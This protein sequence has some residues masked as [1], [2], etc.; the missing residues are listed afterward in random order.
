MA[1][2]KPTVEGV[3][4]AS[5]LAGQMITLST[6]LIALTV[7]F[8]KEFRPPGAAALAAPWPLMVAWACFMLAIVAGLW[9]QM[10]VT[11]SLARQDSDGVPASANAPNVRLPGLLVVCCFVAGIVFTIVS[12]TMVVR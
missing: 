8:V 3:K 10:A 4:A 12:G 11:G 5:A 1:E 7:T 2:P 9:T 6:G